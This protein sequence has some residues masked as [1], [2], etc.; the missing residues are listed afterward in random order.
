MS[1]VGLKPIVCPEGVE[2]NINGT[3]VSVKG[4]K[5]EL[6]ETIDPNIEVKM[7]DGVISLSRKSDLKDH[8]SKHGL[9][10]AL[11]NNMIEGVSQGFKK[12]L[13]LN[14]VGYRANLQGSVIDFTLGYSHHIYF[15]LPAEIKAQVIAEK[16]KNPIV[17]LESHDKQLLGMVASKIKSLRKIEPYKGK[18]ISYVGER[19]RRKAG[20]AAAK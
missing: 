15:R 14:G 10:R 11:I 5:G 20:K 9:Y 8:K 17:S 12:E 19:I 3:S 18:G 7:E 1:R 6:S 13:E 4:P 2:V 16:G